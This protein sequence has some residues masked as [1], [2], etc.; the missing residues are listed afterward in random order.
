MVRVT[1]CAALVVPSAWLAN[2]KLLGLLETAI[3]PVPL[4]LTVGVVL[5][6]FETVRVPV[7]L[8]KAPGVKKTDTLQLELG[9]R[10]LGLRGHVVVVV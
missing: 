5:E 4:R 3:T 7:L 1:V 2:D 6:L 10:V 9:A 8:P